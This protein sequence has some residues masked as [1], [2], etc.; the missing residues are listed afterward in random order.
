[1]AMAPQETFWSARYAQL[2]DRFGIGWQLSA[3]ST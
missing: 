3:E 2:T 1:V